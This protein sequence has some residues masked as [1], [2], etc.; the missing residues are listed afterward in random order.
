MARSRYR[1]FAVRRTRTPTP[2]LPPGRN[3]LR[4]GSFG[5]RGSQ[6]SLITRGT[7]NAAI[8]SDVAHGDDGEGRGEIANYRS[9]TP[10]KIVLTDWMESGVKK[11][12]DECLPVDLGT[13]VN[14]WM[15]GWMG[16]GGEMWLEFESARYLMEGLGL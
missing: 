14:G 15:D 4:A 9:P 10:F 8:C 12:S 5:S 7:F 13:I 6:T 11:R 3:P 16:E 2:S 1:C